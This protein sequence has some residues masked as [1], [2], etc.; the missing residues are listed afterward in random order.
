MRHGG[1]GA[2]VRPVVANEVEIGG[3]RFSWFRVPHVTGDGVDKA[4][5]GL[6][7]DDGR[8]VVWWSGDTAFAPR[9]IAAAA[10]AARSPL[11]SLPAPRS[12]R[13]LLRSLTSPALTLTSVPETATQHN[14]RPRLPPRR[15]LG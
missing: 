6:R 10:N 4:A 8:S 11:F 12:A 14:G 7:I 9:W 3:L 2:L 13:G 5:Y 1:V 15:A